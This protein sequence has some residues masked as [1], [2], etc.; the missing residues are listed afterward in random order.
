MIAK[1]WQFVSARTGDGGG[2]D[3]QTRKLVRKTVMKAFRQKQR[4]DREKKFRQEHLENGDH[5]GPQRLDDPVEKSSCEA[6]SE[7]LE[8]SGSL[9]LRQ[10]RQDKE[11][12]GPS[13][14]HSSPLVIIQRQDWYDYPVHSKFCWPREITSLGLFGLSPPGTC[15]TWHHLFAHCE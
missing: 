15:S 2:N 5:H 11:S 4:L 6:A 13:I 9:V 10:C 7:D 3:V 8:K 1:K 14:D 12:M